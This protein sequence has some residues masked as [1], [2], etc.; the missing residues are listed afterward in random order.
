MYGRLAASGHADR[1]ATLAFSEFGR[2]VAENG[3]GG[4]DHGTAGIAFVFGPPVA[5]RQLVG[6]VDLGDL[7]NGDLRP[8][9]D[10]R[11]VYADVLDWLGGPTDEIDHP[12][13]AHRHCGPWPSGVRS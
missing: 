13:A 1:T 6:G 12:F 8:D 10:A 9:I 5:G 3:S 7:D 11:S 2:R 4:T